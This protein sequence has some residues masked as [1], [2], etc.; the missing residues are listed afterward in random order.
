[1]EFSHLH[2]RCGPYRILVPGDNVTGVDPANEHP[3]RVPLHRAR[4]QG[5]PLMIDAR[6]LLGL[7]PAGPTEPRVNIQW[8][9]TE[10]TLRAVVVVDGVEGLRGGFDAEFLPLPRVP[11]AFYNLFDG[12]VYDT[13][14]GFLLRLRQD[15]L[16]R[17]DDS[18]SR[19][20]FCRAVIGAVPTVGEQRNMPLQASLHSA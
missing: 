17:L 11:P 2:V 4:Q 13:D 15:I 7:D 20:R 19:R 1:M 10:S 18:Y 8:R 14:G 6:L 12:L 16:P 3:V 9:A 5:W